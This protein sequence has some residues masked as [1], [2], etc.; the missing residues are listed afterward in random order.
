MVWTV[1]RKWDIVSFQSNANYDVSILVKDD[2]TVTVAPSTQVSIKNCALF[3]KCITKRDATT[4][5]D[6][7]DL[8]LV[9]PIYNLTEYR[10]FWNSRNFIVLF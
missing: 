5:D 3:T 6:A 4:I 1:T 7:E 8:Y 9:M 2:I 10:L